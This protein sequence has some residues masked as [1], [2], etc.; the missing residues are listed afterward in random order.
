MDKRAQATLVVGIL[1]VFVFVIVAAALLPVMGD[2][3][4]VA[5]VDGNAAASNLSSADITILE[6]WPTFVIIGGLIAVLMA[7][8]LK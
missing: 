6:L 8:G 4:A 7:V 1:G 2:Q 3:I 5:T